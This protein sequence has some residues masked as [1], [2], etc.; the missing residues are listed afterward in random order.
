MSS[1]ELQFRVHEKKINIIN[2][3]IQHQNKQLLHTIRIKENIDYDT[4]K[5]LLK[6][7]NSN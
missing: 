3:I 2:N 5:V 4:L 1:K 6:D 7:F